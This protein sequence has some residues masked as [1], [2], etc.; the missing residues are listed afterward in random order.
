MIV[1]LHKLVVHYTV[2]VC[3]HF[4][5]FFD[6]F[7]KNI[8]FVLFLFLAFCYFLHGRFC[9]A[10][11]CFFWLISVGLNNLFDLTWFYIFEYGSLCT[12][13][14]FQAGWYLISAFSEAS[15]WL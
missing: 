7:F 6:I 3:V 13:Y 15:L 12:G 8:F 11:V 1:I 4:V 5:S 14:S 10:F 9:I 2:H